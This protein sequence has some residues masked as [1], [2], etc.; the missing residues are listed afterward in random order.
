MENLNHLVEMR[1]INDRYTMGAAQVPTVRISELAPGGSW[2]KAIT[3][4]SFRITQLI[5][6]RP[7]RNRFASLH[8]GSLAGL[9]I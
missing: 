5:L 9:V 4:G 2:A 3:I 7:G 6:Q 1:L 8:H